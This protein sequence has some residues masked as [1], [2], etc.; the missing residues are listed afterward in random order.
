M[1]MRDMWIQGCEDGLHHRVEHEHQGVLEVQ[2][3]EGPPVGVRPV[4]VHCL[5]TAEGHELLYPVLHHQRK[6]VRRLR[7]KAKLEM[8]W[9]WRRQVARQLLDGCGSES[10][11]EEV[12][13][14][15]EALGERACAQWPGFVCPSLAEPMARASRMRR[16]L[17]SVRELAA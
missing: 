15:R 12:R 14:L 6:E 8:Q 1:G 3:G 2:Q 17:A 5:Q 9:M 16:E 10:E 4:D 13:R 11:E 7:E